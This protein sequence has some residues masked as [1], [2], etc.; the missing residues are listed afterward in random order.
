MHC[1]VFWLGLHSI[2]QWI[3]KLPQEVWTSDTTKQTEHSMLSAAQAQYHNQQ[4]YTE[5]PVPVT[6]LHC[7]QS[8][9]YSICTNLFPYFPPDHIQASKIQW[10]SCRCWGLQMRT[11]DE[12][13]AQDLCC[14]QW[15]G[16]GPAS[17]V[18]TLLRNTQQHVAFLMDF[19]LQE[20]YNMMWST[21]FHFQIKRRAQNMYGGD[22]KHRV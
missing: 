22:T 21:H 19:Y 13:T 18:P 12:C 20:Q 11:Q 15:N 10:C 4:F 16:L 2:L 14:P 9:L 1:C 6:D 8:K 5:L 17:T 7:W 3:L